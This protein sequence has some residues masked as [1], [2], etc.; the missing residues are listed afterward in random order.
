M[1]FAASRNPISAARVLQVYLLGR[2]PI[3]DALAPFTIREHVFKV[4]ERLEQ[5]LGNLHSTLP[6]CS[7]RFWNR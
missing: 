7:N 5:A 1:S 3:D 4:A 6:H 2:M